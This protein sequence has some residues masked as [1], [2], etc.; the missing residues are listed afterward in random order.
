MKPPIQIWRNGK[1]SKTLDNP[2]EDLNENEPIYLTEDDGKTWTQF[3]PG[4]D[5][6]VYDGDLDSQGRPWKFGEQRDI[7]KRLD[8][9]G[10]I[11][12]KD[13]VRMPNGRVYFHD[14][15]TWAE[16]TEKSAKDLSVPLH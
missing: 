14:G 9:E 3:G 5:N 11:C 2:Y 15:E 10:L 16:S 13:Y 7:C 6:A 12:S 1:L 8:Q 4:Y